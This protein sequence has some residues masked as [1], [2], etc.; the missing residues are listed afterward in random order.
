[1][2][3]NIPPRWNPHQQLGAR[4][5]A[6]GQ[7]EKAIEENREAIRLSP[8]FA[9]AYFV[10]VQAF[11]RLNRFDEA[12]EI[13][14]RALKQKLDSPP[15]RNQLYL[16]AFIRGD[17]AEMKRQIDWTTDKPAE[18]LML[19]L[20][21]QAAAT[22]GRLRQAHELSRRATEMAERRKFL[23]YAGGQTALRAEWSAVLGDCRQARE[24]IA[25][26]SAYPRLPI[27]LFRTSLAHASCGEVRQAQTLTDEAVRKYPGEPVVEVLVPLAQAAI[28]IQRGNRAQALQILQSVSRYERAN[29]FIQNYLRGQIYLSK[30]KGAEAATEFQKILDNRGWSPTSVMYV[31][32]HL[33]LARAA[34]VQRDLAKARKSYQDFFALWKDADRDL[35][36][37]IEAE[38][39]YE[40]V[41]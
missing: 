7:F 5:A 21:S 31:P 33:W 34:V 26:A 23:E 19:D 17:D 27:S 29:F 13:C 28:E 40:R 41:R 38:K 3:K 15:I 22:S 37:L 4:Y 12:R 18:Y 14:E 35:P 6:I 39:E 8:N 32:A 16:L 9:P 2:D 11:I 24:N 30:Q 25:S 10:L 36:I 1:M 20:Q